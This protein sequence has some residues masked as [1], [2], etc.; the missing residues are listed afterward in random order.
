[1]FKYDRYDNDTRHVI[2]TA[3]NEARSRN[4]AKYSLEHVLLGLVAPESPVAALMQQYGLTRADIAVQTDRRNPRQA[5]QTDSSAQP[6][7]YVEDIF[8]DVQQRLEHSGRQHANCLHLLYST[9]IVL[10]QYDS[11][12]AKICDDLHVDVD[13]LFKEV[14]KSIDTQIKAEE[15]AKRRAQLE[16]LLEAIALNGTTVETLAATLV[17]VVSDEQYSEILTLLKK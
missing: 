14:V 4:H 7:A 11:I 17:N 3:M 5:I 10:R 2:T 12:A 13:D 15:A 8:T 6:T 9:L 16:K 1:M